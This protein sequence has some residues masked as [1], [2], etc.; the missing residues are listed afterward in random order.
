MNIDQLL[1]GLGDDESVHNVGLAST[2]PQ[3][4]PTTA[5]KENN[6][7]RFEHP[8]YNRYTVPVRHRR[9]VVSE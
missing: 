8:L 9:R 7:D 2:S 6:I 1:A 5:R 4:Q 3:C